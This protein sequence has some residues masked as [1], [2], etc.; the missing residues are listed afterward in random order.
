[1]SSQGERKSERD[2]I[3][4]WSQP[5][6]N[7]HPALKALFTGYLVTIGVGLTVAFAQILLT[8]GMADG[9]FGLSVDDI[10]YSYYGNREGSLLE[11]KLQGSMKL[12]ADERER[13]ALIKW[14][15]Q[16]SPADQWESTVLPIVSDKCLRCHGAIPGIPDYRTLEGMKAVT[17]IDEGATIPTLARVSH[18]HLFG[19][20]FIFFFICM[21]FTLATGIPTWLKVTAI[22][23]P[24]AF[25][26][27]DIFT[28]WA[29]KYFPVFAYLEMIA[30]FGYSS[31]SAF[32]ILTSLYQ[33]W[34]PRFKPSL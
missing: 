15:R 20:A 10:V 18:I 4:D 11:A 34:V 23:L 14:A 22:A 1:M 8:H 28:W 2:Q 12:M 17:K 30:G 24:Y 5:L 21:I 13:A 32:M 25:L 31:A 33:M 16:G 26:V 19:I 7:I 9:K 6:R 27:I 3:P 29:T